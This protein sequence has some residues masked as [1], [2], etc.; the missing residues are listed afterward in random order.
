MNILRST[1]YSVHTTPYVDAIPYIPYS[2]LRTEHQSWCV[3]NDIYGAEC[4]SP[5]SAENR[6]GSVTSKYPIPHTQAYR[7][8][9]EYIGIDLHGDTRLLNIR[10]KIE[11]LHVHFLPW[12]SALYSTHNQR[13][14][15][16]VQVSGSVRTDHG[17]QAMFMSRLLG[18]AQ[19]PK[20]LNICRLA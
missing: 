6:C 15:R 13:F 5:R 8:L 18:Q 12:P 16:M 3:I 19:I 9:P 14:P 17:S 1:P 20:T 11:S 7:S 4:T 2:V 10:P